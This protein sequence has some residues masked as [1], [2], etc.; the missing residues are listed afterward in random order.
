MPGPFLPGDIEE[1]CSVGR[2]CLVRTAHPTAGGAVLRGFAAYQHADFARMGG[3]V[4]VRLVPQRFEDDGSGPR[5]C[6]LAT[7]SGGQV[8]AG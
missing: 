3:A 2:F 7:V 8:V 5:C 4:A 1:N 6:R